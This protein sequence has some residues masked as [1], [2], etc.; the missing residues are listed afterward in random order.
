MA[1]ISGLPA[2]WKDQTLEYES[3]GLIAGYL[4][5]LQDLIRQH[6]EQSFY[7]DECQRLALHVCGAQVLPP[8][9]FIG[10]IL[11]RIVGIA[12]ANWP[13][14]NPVNELKSKNAIGNSPSAI[15]ATAQLQSL[16]REWEVLSAFVENGWVPIETERSVSQSDWKVAKSGIKIHVEVKY[17]SPIDTVRERFHGLWHGLTLL[18]QY[19]ALRTRKWTWS[20][21]SPISAEY[22]QLGIH[23]T[24]ASCARL[25]VNFAPFANDLISSDQFGS[26]GLQELHPFVDP[27]GP[28][29]LSGMLIDSCGYFDL[30]V[31]RGRRMSLSTE[32]E[33]EHPLI[34]HP[35]GTAAEFEYTGS[36][37]GEKLESIAT[38]LSK[39]IS[40]NQAARAGDNWLFAVCWDIPF[41]WD[42][43]FKSNPYQLNDIVHKIEQVR[44]VPIALWARSPFLGWKWYLGPKARKCW[45]ICLTLESPNNK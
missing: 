4:S 25:L 28:A 5:L 38:I 29:T 7:F 24:M 17:K 26:N 18:N 8:E 20:G 33:S 27:E 31:D 21:V 45:P 44:G 15:H 14:E 11:E 41:W 30:G 37:G 19:P 16:A 34:W 39:T 13:A 2:N 1:I 9:R 10:N 32:R 42:E 3:T 35:Y 6:S 22:G 12:G 43:S 40:K 23:K 36:L